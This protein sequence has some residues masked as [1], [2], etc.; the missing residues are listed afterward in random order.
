M[1]ACETGRLPSMADVRI[2][3][4][5]SSSLTDDAAARSHAPLERENQA[6]DVRLRLTKAASALARAA[7]RLPLPEPTRTRENHQDV[8]HREHPEQ[9]LDGD[10]AAHHKGILAPGVHGLEARL[11][12][13]ALRVEAHGGADLRPGVHREGDG[14]DQRLRVRG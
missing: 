6:L 10:P 11:A 4:S 12:G 13:P 5:G 3:D 14:Q 2:S 7:S 9:A 8:G 1:S